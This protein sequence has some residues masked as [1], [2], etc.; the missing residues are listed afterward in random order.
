MDPFVIQ[1][2]RLTRYFGGC[3]AVDQL[4]FAVPRGSV[5]AV[6]GRNGS[7]KTTLLRMLLG[8]LDP[9]RGSGRILGDGI[10]NIRPAT[11]GRIGYIAEGHPLIDWMRVKDLQAFQKSFFSNW[12][13]HLFTTVIDH[14][15]L[16]ASARAH[17]LSRGQRAGLS[18]ALTLA[19]RPELLVMDDPALGLDPVARRTLLEAMILVTRDAGHTILFTSHELADIERVADHLAIMDLSVLRV[20]CPM[21]TFRE[22]I[23]CLR[24]TFA[25][26]APAAPSLPG[27]L[28]SRRDG[29]T[30][31]L[32]LADAGEGIHRALSA[33]SPLTI[34]ELPVTLEEAVVSYLRDRKTTGSLLQETSLSGANP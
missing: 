6:L 25:D 13:S 20:C 16:S 18:L 27:L 34:E 10:Q 8:M 30:L 32:L 1:T 9:T 24:L 23:K 33:L 5:F 19:G 28:E 2:N 14:F 12:D 17:N 4:S 29:P 21:D 3:C 26:A 7:G 31:R 22:R 15:G 11:R